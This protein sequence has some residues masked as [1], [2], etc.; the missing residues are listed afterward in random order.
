LLPYHTQH[1]KTPIEKSGKACVEIAGAVGADGRWEHVVSV[2][3]DDAIR[4]YLAEFDFIREGMRQDQRE[5][6]GFLGFASAQGPLLTGT[7]A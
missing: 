2:D 6:Q 1:Q 4:G 7:R 5:R 3:D